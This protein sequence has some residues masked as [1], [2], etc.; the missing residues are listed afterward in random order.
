MAKVAMITS[1]AENEATEA[2]PLEGSAEGVWAVG[3]DG[4]GGGLPVQWR[5]LLEDSHDR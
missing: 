3:A 1:M 2:E 5:S 4:G